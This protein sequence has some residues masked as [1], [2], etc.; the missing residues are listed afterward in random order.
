MI[1]LSYAHDKQ[2]VDMF[3]V[4]TVPDVL[5]VHLSVAE[6]L[7]LGAS[8]HRVGSLLLGRHFHWQK[9]PSNH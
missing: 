8:H 3:F 2:W 5:M 6:Q 1:E 4:G 7:P 9:K